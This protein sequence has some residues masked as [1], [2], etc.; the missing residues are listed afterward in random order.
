[1]LQLDGFGNLV[2]DPAIY[3]KFNQSIA[4]NARE[5]MLLRTVDLLVEK[6]GDYRDL[7]TS[8]VAFISRPLAS[9]YNVPFASKAEWTTYTFPE[10]A[11]RS[12]IR[13]ADVIVRANGRDVTTVAQ[14]RSAIARVPNNQAVSLE[15]VRDRERVTLEL[16]RE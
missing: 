11:E 6:Q 14:L 12:G 8:E 1:M 5:Q 2:K 4:E 15:I 9:V 16:R 3:P 10:S 7:F 13:E